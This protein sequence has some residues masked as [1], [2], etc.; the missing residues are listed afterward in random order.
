MNI[1]IPN[2]EILNFETEATVVSDI[3]TS[4][5]H[6]QSLLALLQKLKLSKVMTKVELDEMLS[7][8]G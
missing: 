1:T 4:K 5:M 3:E 2:Y 7:E 6:S 8:V